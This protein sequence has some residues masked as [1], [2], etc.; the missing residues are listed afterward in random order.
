VSAAASVTRQVTVSVTRRLF[1]MKILGLT[2]VQVCI[3]A[4]YVL[5]DQ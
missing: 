2:L 5:S 3:Q 4:K 1:V